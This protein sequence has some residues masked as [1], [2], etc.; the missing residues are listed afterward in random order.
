MG[1]ASVHRAIY[2]GLD[3]NT[4]LDDFNP[5]FVPTPFRLLK[6][7]I[8]KRVDKYCEQ[9]KDWWFLY[10][11]KEKVDKLEYLLN[12]NGKSA[13]TVRLINNID[14]QIMEIMR[15]S[16]KKCCKIGRHATLSWSASFGKTLKKERHIKC[17]LKKEALKSSF[18]YTTTKIKN[19]FLS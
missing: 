1:I 5:S 10:N 14:N 19:Y 2:T 15:C 4:L 18:Q 16:E 11:I 8:P 3:V 7:S 17:Q 12:Q 13:E 6:S 9:M